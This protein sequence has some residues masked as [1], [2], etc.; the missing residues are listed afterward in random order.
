MMGIN[1]I[2]KMKNKYNIG[3][4]IRRTPLKAYNLIYSNDM[5]YVYML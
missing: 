1:Q 2:E 3:F 4:V 5:Y